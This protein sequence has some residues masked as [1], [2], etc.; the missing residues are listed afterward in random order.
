MPFELNA[1]IP[2]SFQYGPTPM[3]QMQSVLTLADMIDKSKEARRKRSEEQSLRELVTPIAQKQ[4]RAFEAPAAL[5][6]APVRQPAVEDIRKR[7]LGGGA[8]VPA[9]LQEQGI[10]LSPEDIALTQGDVN[11]PMQYSGIPGTGKQYTS[12]Q[13]AQLPGVKRYEQAADADYQQKLD[14]YN[15]QKASVQTPEQRIPAEYSWMQPNEY[16]YML[17]LQTISP[18]EAENYQTS[19]ADRKYKLAQMGTAEA[20]SKD[21]RD[22]QVGQVLSSLFGDR[23]EIDT[24]EKEAA[25]EALIGLGYSP[26][27]SRASVDNAKSLM[28][29]YQTSPAMLATQT[30][31]EKRKANEAA[32][33]L[34]RGKLKLE[35]RELALKEKTA[36]VASAKDLLELEK[37]RGEIALTNAKQRGEEYD[38]AYLGQS[39][40]NLAAHPG[41]AV[42]IDPKRLVALA[43][44]SAVRDFVILHG[45]VINQ[46]SMLAASKL[47]GGGQISDY[48]R[49]MLLSS[50]TSLDLN[51]SR[52]AYLAEVARIQRYINW[53]TA[54]P[55]VTINSDQEANAIMGPKARGPAIRPKAPAASGLTPAEQAELDA[56]RRE[57]AQ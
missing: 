53:K 33:A 18:Q 1:A 49:K 12:E 35:E 8:G 43:P 55:T 28:L 52:A 30:L 6:P 22:F 42:G 24:Q 13:F 5:P 57:L 48:E 21:L 19:L 45:N 40:A 34:A 15:R 10:H 41:F 56:L 44:G 29:K 4:L 20:K 26:T 16:R 50:Q 54:N 17:Q 37:L 32:Q 39:L 25:V 47:K 23:A 7:V 36:G 14:E 51:M 31:A 46:I 9:M 27:E 38:T 11:S 3:E 2:M